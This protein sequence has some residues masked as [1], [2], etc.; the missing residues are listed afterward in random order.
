[1]LVKC[2]LKVR[3]W[4]IMCWSRSQELRA[5]GQKKQKIEDSEDVAQLH[6]KT[7]GPGLRSVLI[8]PWVVAQAKP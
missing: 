4:L 2:W 6:L 3:A 1:M 8:H 7:C 5:R